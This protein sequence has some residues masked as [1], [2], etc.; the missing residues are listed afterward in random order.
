MFKEMLE[1]YKDKDF[2]EK[3]DKKVVW[4][5]L[6]EVAKYKPVN[7]SAYET[8]AQIENEE[9]RAGLKIFSEVPR[10]R[11]IPTMRKNTRYC[12][13]VPIFLSAHKEHNNTPYEYWDKEDRAIKFA[14]GNQLY[15]AYETWKNLEEYTEQDLKTLRYD[16][17]HYG[18]SKEYSKTDW[19][20]H[21]VSFAGRKLPSGNMLR[22]ILTQT[23][24][25]NAE[26][27]NRYMILDFENWDNMP[28]ALDIVDVKE[29]IE[30]KPKVEQELPW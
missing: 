26:L 5:F 23:W 14:L 25:A 16:V 9:I 24:M 27:R 12:T 2:K 17:L 18:S 20:R 1:R 15:E 4:N 28:E 13:L 6:A 29:E 21:T 11:L 7:N 8:L 30:L 3:L 22:Y 10:S 19:Q